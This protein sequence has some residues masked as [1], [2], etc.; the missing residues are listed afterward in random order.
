MKRTTVTDV[1]VVWKMK[2]S[3]AD[4]LLGNT[5]RPVLDE[6]VE[7]LQRFAK[8]NNWPLRHVGI[9]YGRDME[10][11]DWEWIE[12]VP[13]LELPFDTAEECLGGFL[14]RVDIFQHSLSEQKRDIFIKMVEFDVDTV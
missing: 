5:G 13:V 1:P 2:E 9:N 3:E 14:D 11:A 8:D 4:R 7:L 10:L 6:V 12:V